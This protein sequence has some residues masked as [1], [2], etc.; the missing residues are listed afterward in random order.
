MNL[1]GTKMRSSGNASTYFVC[2][3]TY[4]YL[5]I[6]INHTHA[7]NDSLASFIHLTVSSQRWA[8][9]TS[10]ALFFRAISFTIRPPIS[11]LP[12]CWKIRVKYSTD[13]YIP[14]CTS[15]NLYLLYIRNI[16]VQYVLVH[17]GTDR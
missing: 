6:D 4:W 10:T 3:C 16:S 2:I 8:C 15:T 5:S 12:V 9:S 17:T 14:V 11:A 1:Q 7:C 13:L